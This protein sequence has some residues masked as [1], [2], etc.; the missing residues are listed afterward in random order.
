MTKSEDLM[1][2]PM[3]DCGA[4]VQAAAC[5]RAL[6]TQCRYEVRDVEAHNTFARRA[7]IG[8]LLEQVSDWQ[9]DIDVQLFIG[10]SG[11]RVGLEDE[12]GNLTSHGGDTLLDT[13]RALAA[14]IGG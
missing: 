5:G 13:L 8:R 2:C 6:C 1:P 7:E 12:S 3:P 4:E 10:G 9:C 11:R 14:E